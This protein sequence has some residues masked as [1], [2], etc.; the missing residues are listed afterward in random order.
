MLLVME[1]GTL[2]FFPAIYFF[3]GGGVECSLVIESSVARIRRNKTFEEP[4]NIAPG[5][6]M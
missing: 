2:L 6:G 5:S 4:V 3:L 1:R